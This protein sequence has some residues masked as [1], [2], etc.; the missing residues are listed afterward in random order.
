MGGVKA[1][2]NTK[3]TDDEKSPMSKSELT[4]TNPFDE[5]QKEIQNRPKK[6]GVKKFKKYWG[7]K[8]PKPKPEASPS[9]KTAEMLSDAEVSGSKKNETAKTPNPYGII[10]VVTEDDENSSTVSPLTLLPEQFKIDISEKVSHTL[11]L[12]SLSPDQDHFK[13]AEDLVYGD[14][15]R[16]PNPRLARSIGTREEPELK[17]GGL[18]KESRKGELQNPIGM[19][20]KVNL[21]F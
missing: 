1:W 16:L 19:N 3:K 17:V 15:S 7:K 8:A 6:N 10:E 20:F 18:Q 4:S 9:Q 5:V 11:S 13:D 21:A 2:K 14:K 12:P